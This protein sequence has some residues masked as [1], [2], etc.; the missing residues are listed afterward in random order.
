LNTAIKDVSLCAGVVVKYPV[1]DLVAMLQSTDPFEGHH[2]PVLI[3]SENQAAERSPHNN[4]AAL[5]DTPVLVFHGE[6]D[7]S[8]PLFHS[9]RLRDALE[10]AGGKIQLEVFDGEGHGFRIPV[11]IAREFAVTEEFLYALMKNAR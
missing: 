10:A 8:V 11:N 5:R 6:Q 9:E 3:G 7:H 2:M 1:V 4:V